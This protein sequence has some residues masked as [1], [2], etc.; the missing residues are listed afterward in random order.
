MADECH[1]SEALARVPLLSEYTLLDT[2]LVVRGLRV[3]VVE[4]GV[5]RGGTRTQG[6][7][8]VDC[9]GVDRPPVKRPVMASLQD[10]LLTHTSCAVL[11]TLNP[12][13]PH[14]ANRIR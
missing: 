2:S 7:G 13:W 10:G 3:L 5:H 8:S 6:A 14:V 4:G 12:G 9:L 1:D 11:S